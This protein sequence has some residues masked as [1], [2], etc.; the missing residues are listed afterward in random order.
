LLVPRLRSGHFS[1]GLFERYQRNEQ[2]LLLADE[3]DRLNLR[4]P[5]VLEHLK[6]INAALEYQTSSGKFEIHVPGAAD[7]VQ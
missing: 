5:G 2:A 6:H 1:T 4:I 7:K 3:S